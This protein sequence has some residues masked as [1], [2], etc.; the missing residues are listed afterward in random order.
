MLGTALYMFFLFVYMYSGA[1][2]KPATNTEVQ[3]TEA[4]RWREGG[5]RRV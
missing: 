3:A 1:G 2:L 5:R 4:E